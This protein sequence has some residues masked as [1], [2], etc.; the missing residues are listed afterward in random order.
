MN[1]LRTSVAAAEEAVDLVADVGS[2]VV[3]RHVEALC[4]CGSD[5][6]GREVVTVSAF[7]SRTS[8]PPETILSRLIKASV[9]SSRAPS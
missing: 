6:D 7:G 9:G 4:G 1:L 2:A 5:S 3:A 8:C